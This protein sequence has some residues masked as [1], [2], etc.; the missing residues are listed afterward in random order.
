MFRYCKR[1]TKFEKKI[2][3]LFFENTYLVTSEQIVS[4][5]NFETFLENLKKNENATS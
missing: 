1:A 2:S 3:H 5:S 4:F